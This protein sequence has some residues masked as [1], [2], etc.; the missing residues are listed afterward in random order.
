MHSV[1]KII[2]KLEKCSIKVKTQ[3]IYHQFYPLLA[4]RTEQFKIDLAK[5][6]GF[7]PDFISV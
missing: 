2:T 3:Q 7:H 1:A 5:S 4:Y 6:Q